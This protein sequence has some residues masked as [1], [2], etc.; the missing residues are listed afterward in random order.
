MDLGEI[1]SKLECRA[2]RSAAPA[3]SSA[4][5]ISWPRAC[6][7]AVG[8]ARVRSLFEAR[9][10]LHAFAPLLGAFFLPVVEITLSPPEGISPAQ[11]PQATRVTNAKNSSLDTL[12]PLA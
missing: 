6:V 4:I 9:A 3:P 10:G 2:T 5:L 1:Q 8:L 7:R 12:N 11:T